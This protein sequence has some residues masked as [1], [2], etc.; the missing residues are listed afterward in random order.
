MA[1]N[2]LTSCQTVNP[3]IRSLLNQVISPSTQAANS[4]RKGPVGI[5]SRLHTEQLR[6]CGSCPSRGKVKSAQVGSVD[7]PP[8]A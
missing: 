8:F 3:F 6:N 2:S 4:S 7:H 5:V 1:A